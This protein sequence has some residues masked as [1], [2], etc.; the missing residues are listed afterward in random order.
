MALNHDHIMEFVDYITPMNE[1]YTTLPSAYEGNYAFIWDYKCRSIAHP[2]H[3]SIVG[4]NP[5][6]GE[7]Q[8]PWLEGTLG[9]ERDYVN[10]GFLKDK[11]GKKIP[12]LVDGKPA[13]ARDTPFYFWS[14]GG[15]AEWLAA[16]PSW[17]KLADKTAGVSWGE[18]LKKYNGDREI[19]PQF[20]ERVLKNKDSNPVKDANGNYILDY[21][22]RDKTPAAALTKAGFVGLD[23]RYLNNAPQCTGWMDLTKNGGSGSFYILWS[24]I[25][26]PTTAGAIPYYTGQYAPEN[27]NGSKR[28]FAFVTIGAGIEDFTAPARDTEKKLA[29]AIDSSMLDNTFRLAVTSVVFFALVVLIAVLLSSYLTKNIKLLIDGLSHFRSGRRHFRLHSNTRDEFDTLTDSFNEMADS[30]VNSVNGPLSIIDIEHNVIYMNDNALKGNKKTLS[31]AIGAH[32]SEISA[33]PYGSKYCP[34]T[35]L[36]NNRE[37]DVLYWERNG[38]YYKGSAHYLLGDDGEKIGYIIATNDVTEIE[39]ARKRADRKSVV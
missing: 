16:N 22:S 3:H 18:F 7:P 26:K 27:Q 33:Y 25:Y 10:G 21:Q 36:H 4:Y 38:H 11:D 1:R 17:D 23:G 13:L 5:L 12:I 19:L 14:A 9:F 31:E 2:R 37:A 29:D 34:I 30:I 28:G 15:G 6:T 32:Y 20:G 8:V 39:E 35:A 24:G